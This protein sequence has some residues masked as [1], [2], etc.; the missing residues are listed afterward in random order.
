MQKS[1]MRFKTS[2]GWRT[3][4]WA[5]R[6]L[7]PTLG[8]IA[9]SWTSSAGSTQSDRQAIQRPLF[10]RYYALY[11]WTTSQQIPQDAAAGHGDLVDATEGQKKTDLVNALGAFSKLVDL[12]LTVMVLQQGQPFFGS[13][14]KLD[15]TINFL[16]WR[17]E[18]D[19]LGIRLS[20]DDISQMIVDETRGEFTKEAA[21][22]VDAS[23]RQR[24]KGGFSAE[25]LFAALGDEFRARMASARAHRGR[26]R[27]A[28]RHTLTAVPDPLTPEESWEL[29]KDARTTDQGRLVLIDVPVKDLLGQGDGDAAR[30]R[31]EEAL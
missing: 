26:R 8:W 13:T 23:L 5:P 17:Y 28:G 25:T 16:I 7:H 31:A 12:D 4:T 3:S 19:R 20:N 29:F 9:V 10:E 1:S 21:E 18:A 15:D 2:V 14:E 24:L 27:G 6:S 30:R 11:E 22:L